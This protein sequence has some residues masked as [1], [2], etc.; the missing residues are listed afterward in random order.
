MDPRLTRGDPFDAKQKST[1]PEGISDKGLASTKVLE[2][3]IELTI[4]YN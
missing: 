1:S 4:S 3:E 2:R